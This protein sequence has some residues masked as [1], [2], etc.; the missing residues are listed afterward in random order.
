MAT[1][2]K[3]VKSNSTKT[4]KLDLPK[5]IFG[6]KECNHDLIKQV[7][8]AYLGNSRT[9]LAST[10]TRGMVS[11][12]G[13]KPWRQKGTGRARVGSS[14]NP[15]WR[16]GGIVFGPTGN[17]NYTKKVN[18]KAYRQALKQVLS[19]KATNQQIILSEEISLKEP[20]TAEARKLIN[21]LGASK[22]TLIITD[23]QNDKLL[24]STANLKNVKLLT[25][26][27]LNVFDLLN[28]DSIILTKPALKLIVANL[29]PKGD[30]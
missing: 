19:N 26:S 7:Y 24:M 15:I 5:E 25:A 12:G 21:Q 3:T 28:A 23:K 13:K 29:T 1:Q 11:G 27:Y 17:E 16:G 20:K 30:K 6:L 14:R 10:K 22:R 18:T 2:A 8:L 4:A 9:N